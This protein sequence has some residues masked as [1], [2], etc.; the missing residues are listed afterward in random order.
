M[1]QQS[2]HKSEDMVYKKRLFYDNGIRFVEVKAKL[3]NEYKPPAPNLKSYVHE[4]FSHSAGLVNRGTSHYSATLTLLFYSKKEYADWLSF[5]GS[6]HKYYDEKGTI[7]LGIVT[8]QPDIQTAE[9][10]TK[11]IIQVQMSLIRKQSDDSHSK[12]QFMDLK[13]HWASSY[14]EEMEQRGMV[15]IHA[16]EGEDSPYFR[17]DES[18]TRAEGITFLMRSYRYVDRILRGH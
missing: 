1:T 7:Y 16:A 17:P 14:I 15:T 4:T 6:E 2:P 11:Y 13:G 5:I 10:E 8:G 18:C 3:I 9:M 12:S